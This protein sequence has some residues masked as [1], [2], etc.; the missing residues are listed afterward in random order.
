MSPE[1][2]T[3]AGWMKYFEW[4]KQQEEPQPE[5]PVASDDIDYSE[6]EEFDKIAQRPRYWTTEN[7]GSLSKDDIARVF[8]ELTWKLPIK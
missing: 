1:H 5:K 4:A 7:V 3:E 6:L 8:N 2:Q